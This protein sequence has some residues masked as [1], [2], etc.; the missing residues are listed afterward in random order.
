MGNRIDSQNESGTIFPEEE[1][2][3]S[4]PDLIASYGDRLLRSAYLMCGHSRDA[5]DI[6]QET[7]CRA[8]AALQ[9][10]RGEAGVYTWLFSIMRNVYRKQCRHE[11]RFF[12]FLARQPR[13][14][15]IEDTPADQWER[16]STQTQLLTMLQK[17]PAKQ[18]EIVILRFVNNLKIADIARI[19]SLPEGTVKS[20]L[21]NAGNRLQ[22]LMG[23]RCSRS[24]S[25]CEEA[26]EV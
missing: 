19:L 15:L 12:H 13:V 2:T 8:L 3:L 1:S 11:M 26:H 22:E 21:F 7:F 17:L 4:L 10:F 24:I 14:E 5:Q 23:A 9:D 25:E 6:V 20:R 18:R 16:Q